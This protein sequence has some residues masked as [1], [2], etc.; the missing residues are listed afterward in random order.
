MM[1]WKNFHRK[2]AMKWQR[3]LLIENEFKAS[4]GINAVQGEKGYSNRRKTHNTTH[5]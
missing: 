1:K 2:H 4:I 5:A 3:L